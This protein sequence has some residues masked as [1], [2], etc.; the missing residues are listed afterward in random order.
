MVGRE[1]KGFPVFMVKKRYSGGMN[2]KVVISV[3]LFLFGF[4]ISLDVW[5]IGYILTLSETHSFLN[6]WQQMV[7]SILGAGAPIALYLL[8]ENY[9]SRK[10]ALRRIEI[11]NTYSIQ[12]ILNTKSQLLFFVEQARKCAKDDIRGSKMILSRVNFPAMNGIYN[13]PTNLQSKLKSYYLHNKVL[14]FTAWSDDINA[15]IK[16]FRND[17]EKMM[18]LGEVIVTLNKETFDKNPAAFNKMCDD[19]A[20]QLEAFASTVENYAGTC[21]GIFE[22]SLQIRVYNKKLR[23]RT[24]ILTRLE[25]EGMTQSNRDMELVDEIDARLKIEVE[26]E[27]S[28]I[29]K[30]KEQ[31]KEK[32]LSNQ[33][34]Q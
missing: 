14:I 8:I 9:F 23:K 34:Q 15:A 5:I 28:V 11:A 16:E 24:A 1:R 32:E 4:G 30:R 10:E 18:R 17:Y 31:L 21:D 29:S 33:V 7:G 27:K 25:Y 20:G 6:D 12:T 26:K 3:L 19:F 13:E 2:N 22:I